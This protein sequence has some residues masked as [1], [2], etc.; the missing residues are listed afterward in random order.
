MFSSVLIN[1]VVFNLL[2][3]SILPGPFHC[4]VHIGDMGSYFL[5]DVLCWRGRS[6]SW[7][8]HTG[9]I[10]CPPVHL[11]LEQVL[12]DGIL[13]GCV[14]SVSLLAMTWGCVR[15]RSLTCPVCRSWLKCCFTSTE[16]VG[17][18]GTGAQDVHLDFHTASEL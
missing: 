7:T 18:L 12:L 9:I 4:K 11:S 10:V 5:G 1:S 8:H 13:F 14:R 17:L 6:V 16:T 15:C 2:C 3:I